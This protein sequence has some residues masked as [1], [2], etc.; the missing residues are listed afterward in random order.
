MNVATRLGRESA[1]EVT[2]LAGR[3]TDLRVVA[4]RGTAGGDERAA[5]KL[6]AV[7]AH[8]NNDDVNTP[9]QL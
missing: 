2:R 9:P 4:L 7:T 6:P 1:P 8:H 3:E 5:M